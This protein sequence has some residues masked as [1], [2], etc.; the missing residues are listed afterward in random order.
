[1]LN[2]MQRERRK[3]DKN[4]LK[5]EERCTEC[6]GKL[7]QMESSCP[8]QLL[9]R[10]SQGHEEAQSGLK[11][12]SC[13]VESHQWFKSNHITFICNSFIANSQQSCLRRLHL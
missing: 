3:T 7:V 9:R 5:C 2:A 10:G 1:M 4:R 13:V 11:P 6:C 8:S 12:V